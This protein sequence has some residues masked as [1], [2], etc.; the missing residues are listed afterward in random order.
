MDYISNLLSYMKGF[1]ISNKEDI[2]EEPII[3]I[4]DNITSHPTIT[5]EEVYYFFINTAN[6]FNASKL[7]V[8]RLTEYKDKT[9]KIYLL[10]SDILEPLFKNSVIVDDNKIDRIEYQ[11][12]KHRR[13]L[14]TMVDAI[15]SFIEYNKI[16]YYTIFY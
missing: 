14:H 7:L 3:N 16:K 13:H 2:I 6:I 8:K 11:L 1:F 5:N 4:I 12:S 15:D 10:K 9:I